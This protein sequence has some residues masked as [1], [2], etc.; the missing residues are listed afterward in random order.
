M[1]SSNPHASFGRN[2]VVGLYRLFAGRT[3]PREFLVADAASVGSA[4]MEMLTPALEASATV[5]YFRIPD[6]ERHPFDIRG[7]DG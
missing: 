4:I 5:S 7:N 2:G 3:Y 6:F 1:A